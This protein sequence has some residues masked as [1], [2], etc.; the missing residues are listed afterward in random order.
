[1]DELGEPRI[2]R[3][4]RRG[5]VGFDRLDRLV[6][7]HE[8]FFPLRLVLGGLGAGL[9]DLQ[10]LAGVEFRD[11]FFGPRADGSARGGR[12]KASGARGAGGD[13]A[14]FRGRAADGR[15]RAGDSPRRQ[16]RWALRGVGRRAHEAGRRRRR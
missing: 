8:R 11:V 1:V 13:G 9:V 3:R 16:R 12:E 4:G 7:L 14:G 15:E 2:E 5:G 6:R 10:H